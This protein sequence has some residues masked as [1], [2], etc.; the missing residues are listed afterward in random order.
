M[1][2]ISSMLCPTCAALPFD[3]LDPPFGTQDGLTTWKLGTLTQISTRQCV[4]CK[5]VTQAVL[6]VQRTEP[7]PKFR[8][9]S[10]DEEIEIWATRERY[11]KPGLYLFF[12]SLGPA[13]GTM[14][15]VLREPHIVNSFYTPISTTQIDFSRVRGWLSRCSLHQPSCYAHFDAESMLPSIFPGLR[16]IRFIDVNTYCLVERHSF[17]S[18]VAL[19]YVWGIATSFRLTKANKNRLMQPNAIRDVWDLLPKTIQDAIT[20]VRMIG[21]NYLWVDSLCLVQNDPQDVAS[22]TGVMDLIYEYSTLTIA[23]AGGR[24]AND[25]LPGVH[26]GSRF[27]EEAI[28]EVV[29]GLKL[30]VYTDGEF[31][32]EP[33]VYNSRAWTLQE[34]ALSPRLLCFV[35]NQ[36]FFRCRKAIYSEDSQ[37]EIYSRRSSKAPLHQAMRMKNPAEGYR[38]A[39][40]TY[41]LRILSFPADVHNAMAGITR[42][43]SSVMNCRFLEGMPTAAFDHFLTFKGAR[44]SLKRRNGFP[45]YSW[46]GWMGPLFFWGTNLTNWIPESGFI[47]DTKNE[48][49]WLNE[50]TWIVWYKRNPPGSTS[51]ACHHSVYESF[52]RASASHPG[53]RKRESFASRYHPGFDTSRTSPSDVTLRLDTIPSYPILQFWT[54]SAYY[55]L[56]NIDS[57]RA[58]ADLVDRNGTVIGSLSLDGFEETEFFDSTEPFEFIVLAKTP[59][60]RNKPPSGISYFVMC[61]EWK[62]GIA[63]RRGM[64]D[65]SGDMNGLRAS[66]EPGPSWKEI[67]L[68]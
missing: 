36:V 6:R 28:A 10:P 31:R 27:A 51:L 57:I 43:F 53:Y 29:P 46:V 17:S 49:E 59:R 15:G 64:G 24:D 1:P 18:Y 8:Q 19:S 55:K 22:G 4:F 34:Y 65:I 32:L 54:V 37:D 5:L 66:F 62:N 48:N 63:E 50:N 9:I 7:A 60:H 13:S 35:D 3:V 40:E 41:T 42:R 58:S 44:S 45:S 16:T 25:G 23:A 30:A 11:S 67:I 68:A 20:T 33:T 61:L 38:M 39:V 47:L 2:V 52:A 21:E 14:I 56:F 12:S 26:A